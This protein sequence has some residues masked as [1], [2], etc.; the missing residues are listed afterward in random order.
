MSLNPSLAVPVPEQT[1]KIA[2]AA[3]PKGTP[4]LTLRDELGTLC[5]DEDFSALFPPRGQPALSP[6]LLALVTLL[7][8]RENLADRQ[9]A[10]AVR[11]RID[12][13]YLLGLELDDPG[14]D[15]SVLCEFRARLVAGGAEM[16]L[17]E[18]LLG[19]CRELG[20]V[21]AKGRQRT[22]STHVL[23]SVRTLGRL[24]LVGE[25][26]RAA[27]NEIARLE[28][29]WLRGVA[30]K[31]WHE[32]Y[33][34]RVEDRRLPKTAP[35]REAYAQTVGEDGFALLGLL[36]APEAPAGLAQLPQASVLRTAWAR[37]YVR[38]EPPAGVAPGV[39]FKTNQEVSQAEEKVESPYDPEARYR[40]KRDTHWT[41]YM[42]HV[43]ETCD[44]GSVHLVTHVHTTPADV[45]EAMCTESIHK[46]LADKGLPPGEHLVDA[47]YVSAELLVSSRDDYGIDLVGPARGNPTWQAKVEGAYP[48]DL[49]MIDWEK[50]VA[51]C[52]Q[53]VTSAAWRDHSEEEGK[54]YH[55]VYFPKAACLDC[56]ARA[57]CT[58]AKQLPRRLYLHP[59]AEHEALDA[60]RQR[61]K[62]EEG[63]LLYAQRAGVEGTLSQGVRAFGARRTRY[64][65]LAK[66]HLQQI[67]T[68]VA[69]NIDRITAWL[70]GRPLAETRTSRFAELVA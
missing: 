65:G 59:R 54:P 47:A 24:E 30:P 68:A 51:T 31:D 50:R 7:Q 69:M 42:V 19:Q 64:R 63:R 62:T 5:R 15:F 14:F 49:F 16:Q 46:A 61:L 6:W 12:W 52:P 23:A 48:L 44:E 26:L 11:A 66:T 37:H 27:L 53:G 56:Q 3:F 36:E 21:K 13:K 2:R 38:D 70:A 18:G 57:L 40:D 58:R 35:E 20:L 22:D 32:R 29:D 45:H 8:F 1:A 28:P 33:G 9:A 60:A 34:R 41:G 10:E 39:R 55:L 67:M 4:Y 43:S 25:T 17:L